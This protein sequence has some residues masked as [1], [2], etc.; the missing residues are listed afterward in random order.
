MVGRRNTRLDKIMEPEVIF[1]A[2]DYKRVFDTIPLII[3]EQLGTNDIVIAGGFIRDSLLGLSPSD[4]DIFVKTKDL[5]NQLASDVA[6]GHQ[7][8]GITETSCSFTLINN[9]LIIQYVYCRPFTTPESL[10]NE[11]DF[12]C[13][14]VAFSNIG[15]K[16]TALVSKVE[17]FEQDTRDRRLVFRCANYNKGNLGALTRAFKFTAKGWF[18]S[19]EEMAK[20]VHSYAAYNIELRRALRRG[21]RPTGPWIGV[22]QVRNSA[23]PRYNPHNQGG[24][25]NTNGRTE[26]F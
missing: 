7:G 18:L 14:G 6:Y 20:I 4:I 17:G 25:E 11:F 26:E 13:C 15:N 22:E 8:L 19:E 21:G 3:R 12:R 24:E 23:N 1:T 16:T 5:A 10:I 9:G 2:E